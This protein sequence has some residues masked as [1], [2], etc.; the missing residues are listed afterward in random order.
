MQQNIAK[1]KKVM[2]KVIFKLP[3]SKLWGI[4]ETL[5]VQLQFHRLFS[6]AGAKKLTTST[7]MYLIE[8]VID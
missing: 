8:Y 6:N 4:I 5:A 7:Y 1:D 2:T 3:A